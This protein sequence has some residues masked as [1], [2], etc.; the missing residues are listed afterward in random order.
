[1]SVH[2]FHRLILIGTKSDASSIGKHEPLTRT[3]FPDD[4]LGHCRVSSSELISFYANSVAHSLIGLRSHCHCGRPPLSTLHA[5]LH[6]PLRPAPLAIR[7]PLLGPRLCTLRALHRTTD[8][9]LRRL[10]SPKLRPSITRA[11]SDEHQLR[12]ASSQPATRTCLGMAGGRNFAVNGRR[13]LLLNH[14]RFMSR[15]PLRD[16]L[17]ALRRRQVAV[18]QDFVEWAYPL[19]FKKLR[20]GW[21][22]AARWA[23]HNRR[24]TKFPRTR[25]TRRRR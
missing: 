21:T 15:L 16:Q 8:C 22:F 11:Q 14:E 7:R 20:L 19:T 25:N 1:M 5:R 18:D 9:L 2:R 12:P 6:G 17:G 10:G 23:E 4:V 13:R 24:T 3:N